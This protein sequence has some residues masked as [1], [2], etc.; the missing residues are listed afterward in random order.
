MTLD[1]FITEIFYKEIRGANWRDKKQGLYNYSQLGGMSEKA[2]NFKR[3][4]GSSVRVHGNIY[5]KEY[6]IIRSTK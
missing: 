4:R 5:S 3:V 6:I 2:V 1:T